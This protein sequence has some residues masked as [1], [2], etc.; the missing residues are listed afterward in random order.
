MITGELKNKIDRVWDA[1]WSGGI[2]NPLEVI[3][4]ITYLLFIRRLD[5]LNTLAEKK[6]RITGT[7]EGIIFRPDQQ[8][9]RWSKFKHEESALM[10]KTVADEVFPFLRTLGGDS[11]TYSV[12][13]KDARFTIPTPQLLSRVVDMLDAIPMGDRDT[14]GVPGRCEIHGRAD[15]VRQSHRRR[16]H[17]QRGNGPGTSVRVS[18]HRPCANRTGRQLSGFRRAGHCRHP[19][20]GES[21]RRPDQRHR[22]R[23]ADRVAALNSEW[24]VSQTNNKSV[25][26]LNLSLEGGQ[27]GY[28]LCQRLM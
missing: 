6:A 13:M 4:Q 15:P 21:Q 11:S 3:E 12:H 2:S 1:F 23:A 18:L 24:H 22:L 26:C 5:D 7:K 19:A 9:L 8:H 17:R 25:A 10:H 20:H 14:K 28:R 27:T 16:T